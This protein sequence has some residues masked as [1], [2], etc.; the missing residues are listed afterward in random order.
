VG[1]VADRE[2]M[3]RRNFLLAILGIT[4]SLGLF[5]LAAPISRYLYPV[6]RREAEPKLEVAQ[7]ADLEPL[8]E[9]VYFDYQETPAALILEE[10]GT[11]RAFYLVC[12]HFG[13]ITKWMVEDKIFYCPCH[14]GEFAPDGTVV[15]GPPP[16]PLQELKVVDEDGTLFVEGTV[17]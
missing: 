13:C 2:A 4:G 8:G 11:P 10:D 17:A 6:V 3:T 1:G 16:K 5:G 15:G 7:L 9:A 14:A 12:T